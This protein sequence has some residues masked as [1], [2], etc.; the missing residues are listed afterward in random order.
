MAIKASIYHLTHYR[1]DRPVLLGPQII[2]LRPAPHSRTRVLSHSLKVGPQPHFVNHQQDPYGNW[3]ARFVF[4]EPVREL[5]IEVDLVA[6][7]AVYNP[8]D[9]FVEESAE[10][11]PFAY[12]EELT[13]DLVIYRRPEPVGP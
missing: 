9:F 11:W 2:R 7:M 4:P 10:A 1:Y 5:K 3:L 12:P 6:D 8:F 13:D